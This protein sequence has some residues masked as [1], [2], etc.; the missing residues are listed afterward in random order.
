MRSKLPRRFDRMLTT[1]SAGDLKSVFDRRS[2][3]AVGG[4]LHSTAIGFLDCPDELITW[5]TGRGLSVDASDET[6]ATPLYRR[7]EAGRAEQIP[8]LVSLGADVNAR[9]QSSITPLH[10]AAAHAHVEAV[11]A[12]LAHGADARAQFQEPGST[13]LLCA[14]QE[15]DSTDIVGIAE[16]APLLLAAGDTVTDEMREFTVATG[17]QLY[18]DEETFSADAFQQ[19]D[20]AMERLYEILGVEEEPPHPPHDGVSPIIVPEGEMFSQH[21]ALTEMLVPES[22]PAATVQGELIRITG[23]VYE[24]ISDAEDQA[25]DGEDVEIEWSDEQTRLMAALHG[26]FAS[27]VALSPERLARVD[28]D[29]QAAREGWFAPVDRLLDNAVAWVSQNPTPM[30][31]P[32][33]AGEA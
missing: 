16:I 33:A 10:A 1:K 21:I 32:K 4:P 11:R 19:A 3:D 29:V 18:E 14:L 13:P 25:G 26:Y 24:H 8:L 2:V 30:P 5:L 20:A 6:G 23:Q 15:A 17:E 28:E 7:A 12:L 9:E 31:R 27:G 22:G